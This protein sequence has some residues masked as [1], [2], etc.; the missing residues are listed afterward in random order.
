MIIKPDAAPRE[1]PV[2]PPSPEGAAG[3][4]HGTP[5]RVVSGLYL[6]QP[7]DPDD[8]SLEVPQGLD[9]REPTV[10]AP[11]A[12]GTGREELRLDVDGSLP[13][14]TASGVVV[15]GLDRVH[16][17][18]ALV[19]LGKDRWQGPIH[20]KDG[21]TA[22][23]PYTT[24]Q[25][26]VLGHGHD[27]AGQQ[28][29]RVRFEAP[30]GLHRTRRFRYR[31]PYFHTVDFEFDAATGE[32]ATTS[33][34]TG[35]HPNRPPTLPAEL[36]SIR[37]VFQRAGFDV[38]ESPGGAVPITGA[39]TDALWSDAEMHDAM[40]AFW[41]RFS[42]TAE[43]AMWVFFASLHE[44]G[45]DLGG[46]MF[47][48][49]GPNHRQGTAIFNDAFISVPPA[50]D[51]D[52]QAW[53]RRMVFWTAVHE[54]GHAFN[55]AHSWQ[56][57][58]G[59]PWRPG[60]ADEPEARSFMNYPFRVGGGQ[61]AFFADFAYRFSDP[62]LLFLR[63]APERFVQMGN[64]AWFDHHGFAEARVPQ[65]QGLRLEVRVNRVGGV[66][67][68]LEPVLL[69]LKLTNVSSDPQLVD[70]NALKSLDGMTVVITP[71]NR[72]TREFVPFARYCYTP[73]TTVLGPGESL[74]APLQVSAGAQGWDIAEPGSY[75]IQV[76]LRRGE[77]DLLSNVLTV[78]IRP[79]A[80]RSEEFTAQD[81]FTEDVGR[82]LVFGGSAVLSDAN[83]VLT[84]VVER[85][86]DRRI[87]VHAALAL[88]LPLARDHKLL[89][90]APGAP[91][92]I[93]IE[94]KPARPERAEELL[95]RALTSRPQ[96]AA[97][98]LG[99]IGYVQSSR[100]AS[101]S[102]ARSDDTP[103]A[104]RLLDVAHQTMSARVVRKRKVLTD[105]LDDLAEQRDRYQESGATVG[106][107]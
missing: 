2:Q 100:T 47:D 48:D 68:F 25:I 55:L 62:E 90:S 26:Q 107:R 66:F 57:S 35:A 39:G 22:A 12:S 59:T 91:A 19:P 43:W 3:E 67:E 24:V 33:V 87:A 81:V 99:H 58:R 61:A 85:H 27:D 51:P 36:L 95:D 50:G 101:A 14:R 6:A 54:M 13:Q 79:P 21:S 10:P 104:V 64:A 37:S 38:T 78:R 92:G 44:E 1:A 16:W 75:R 9:G 74:Y 4:D 65:Q 34:D 17:I 31:S 52:P 41:S 46:I 93:R 73:G 8:V 56:K 77:E 84:E 28:A 98:T 96:D 76:A 88:G 45:T 69:E 72:P 97:E 20:Y 102:L 29:A 60:L 63:H 11:L 53:V 30:G 5:R 15:L 23:F 49:I 89:M 86:G 106:A 103:A 70:A 83:D 32:S 18:A 71:Q 40:Q 7:G 80:D 42:A 82:A 94:T 105:V